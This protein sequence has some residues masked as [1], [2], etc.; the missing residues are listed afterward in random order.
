[1]AIVFVDGVSH[2]TTTAQGDK[3]YANI[4]QA[5]SAGTGAFGTPSI[6]FNENDVN[7]QVNFAASNEREFTVYLKTDATTE[8]RNLWTLFDNTFPQLFADAQPDGSIKIWQ[9]G[10]VVGGGFAGFPE[11]K[12]LLGQSAA[13]S[14]PFWTQALHKVS[15]L[16][17]GSTGTLDY[18]INGSSILSLAG[19][20]TA[21]ST[22]LQSTILYLGYMNILPG[23]PRVVQGTWSHLV[24]ADNQGDITGQPRLG[25]LFPDGAGAT[26][27][28][29]PSAGANWQNVDETTP[30]DDTTY[31]ESATVGNIDTYTMQNLPGA[32]S[33]VV[34]VAVT[35]YIKKTDAN[36]RTVAAVLRIGGT[37]Y[38]HATSKGVPGDYAFLQWIWLVS[39][40]TGVAFTVAEVNALEAGIKVTA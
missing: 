40:A 8:V 37:D 22:A 11:R 4:N 24:I 16:H 38:I 30:D 9:G 2:F 34:C 17:H 20:N 3:K 13:N 29:T 21:P 12:V 26:S 7:G 25:G 18:S 5:P 28:W 36:A 19:I 23:S 1:M 14:I 33:S 27:A 32:A 35:I 6:N 10:L 15:I 39:P 31:N